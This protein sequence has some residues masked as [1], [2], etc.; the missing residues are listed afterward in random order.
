MHV[1]GGCN[2]NPKAVPVIAAS[3]GG[4]YDS[5]GPTRPRTRAGA[6]TSMDDDMDS[7][8]FVSKLLLA[9]FE[10][11]RDDIGATFSIVHGKFFR[12]STMAR[13]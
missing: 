6:V 2:S 8:A 4:F 13:K 1:P 5:R 10:G 9:Q 3:A 7:T 12:R 11:Q